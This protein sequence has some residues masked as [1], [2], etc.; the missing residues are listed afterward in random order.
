M[1]GAV[2]HPLM[3]GGGGEGGGRH[4]SS[5]AGLAVILMNFITLRVRRYI[6]Y[7]T[8]TSTEQIKN[9][10]LIPYKMWLSRT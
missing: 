4:N 3:G 10:I 8:R 6:Q 7:S 1:A 5:Q 2:S 9:H